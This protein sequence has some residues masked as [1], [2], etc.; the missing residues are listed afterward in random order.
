MYYPLKLSPSSLITHHSS[1]ITHLY[2][3]IGWPLAHSF[4]KTYF[5][6]KFLR[7][8]IKDARYELFPL[9]NIADF[10]KLCAQHPNLKG[11]NVTIPHKESVIPF[12]D[13]LDETARAVGAVNCIKIDENQELTGYNTDVIGFEASLTN[14]LTKHKTPAQTTHTYILGTGG[15]SKAVAYV[16]QKLNIP[17]HF[18]SRTPSQPN[19]LAYS[20]LITHLSSLITHHSSLI[21]HHSSLIAHHSSLIAHHS[22]FIIINTTPLGTFPNIHEM[23]P[24]PLEILKAGNLVFDLVYNPA[25]TLLLREARLRGCFVQNGLDMLHLQAEAAWKI[26]QT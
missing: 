23:P 21:T 18:V 25:E 1:L 8:S 11:I 17:F 4:S 5:S 3:L 20:S 7:E 10:P 16:L 19:E 15:A 6:E 14:F 9:E 22:S 24:I 26:W 13:K 2:A 12:L